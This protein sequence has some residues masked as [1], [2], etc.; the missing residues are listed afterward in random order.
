MS[1]TI[2][3]TG[4]ASGICAATAARLRQAGHKVIGADLRNAEI[5][6]D[7][8]T[9]AGRA[10]LVEQAAKLAPE[11]LDGVIA[12]AGVATI[13]NPQ[14]IV[15][16]NYFGALATLEGLRPLLLRSKQPRAVVIAST[17]VLLT[18]NDELV[19]ACLA[20]DEQ[21]AKACSLLSSQS[22]YASSKNALALWLRRAAV[23]PEWAGA[24]IMLNG[25]G[26][27]GVFTPMTVPNFATPEGRATMH[28]V[29]PI[30]VPEHGQPE[31]IAEVLDFLVNLER[32]YLLGQVIFVDGGT[33]AFLRPKT[34]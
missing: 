15:A 24:G 13:E 3:V 33:D 34:P 9:T 21:A 17:A 14:L 8:A 19:A 6:I 23:Q 18:V 28:Q 4:S 1:R 22:V 30:A 32:S 29:A 16:V 7:L 31:D 11:G 25:V 5:E 2:L 10:A 26:P 20:G 27:G 12:G